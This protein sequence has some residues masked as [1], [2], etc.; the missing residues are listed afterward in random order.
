MQCFA[1]FTRPFLSTEQVAN[2][3]MGE[4]RTG[5]LS[6]IISERI[7]EQP[8]SATVHPN[9]LFEPEIPGPI[10]ILYIE[11]LCNMYLKIVP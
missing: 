6:V 3:L 8:Q 7:S 11:P 9:H 1:L 5:R 10:V 4:M 2:R